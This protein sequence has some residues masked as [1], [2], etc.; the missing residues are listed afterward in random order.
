[1]GL[2]KAK[3]NVLYACK[4][5]IDKQLAF[6]TGGNISERVDNEDLFV[7]TPSGMDYMQI[8]TEDLIV[9]DF[10]GNIVEGN[11]KPSIETSMH[12]LILKNRPD[13]KSVIHTHSFYATTF[14]SSKNAVEL[15]IYNTEGLYYLGANINIAEYAP[16]GS[17]KLANLA[18]ST[19]G[20]KK[21]VLLKN[22]G[23]ICVG[24]S[25]I[26]ALDVAQV[27]ERACKAV[28]LANLFGGVQEISRESN[29]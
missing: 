21:A 28:L 1:M 26:E 22:H 4:A 19:I 10:D 2:D 6:G 5:M 11:R 14:A 29:S 7:I 17:E 3:D 27:L 20:D 24:K 25:M 12:R 16:S 9:V 18:V 23:A 8:K 13:V 15:P